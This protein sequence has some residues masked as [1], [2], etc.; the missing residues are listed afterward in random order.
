MNRT[1]MTKTLFAIL[2]LLS[3]CSETQT[4]T[5]SS[6][7]NVL[8]N[9]VSCQDSKDRFKISSKKWIRNSKNCEWAGERK[10][11]RCTLQE[12]KLNCPRTCD[13]CECVDSAERFTI[14][15][16]GKRKSCLWISRK[17]KLWRCEMFPILKSKCPLTCRVCGTATTVGLISNLEESTAPSYYGPSQLPSVSMTFKPSLIEEEPLEHHTSNP[18]SSPTSNPTSRP[19]SRP[20][21][22]PSRSPTTTPTTIPTSKSI[23]S[24][25]TNEPSVSPGSTPRSGGVSANPSQL[26]AL[27]SE[28]PTSVS[29]N[30]PSIEPSLNSS[31]LA[32]S[33]K[34]SGG[35]T[36]E[37]GSIPPT[38][39]TMPSDVPSNVLSSDQS[40]LHASWIAPSHTPS[41]K[42]TRNVPSSDPINESS[43]A[44]LFGPS[45]DISSTSMLP[46]VERM[47][48]P[49]STPTTKPSN[50]MSFSTSNNPSL[51]SSAVPT[52]SPSNQ[53]E[54][55]CSVAH[56]EGMEFFASH[57][58]NGKNACVKFQLFDGGIVSIDDTNENIDCA[59]LP[60]F[61]DR[62]IISRFD[63]ANIA[64]GLFKGINHNTQEEYD[65][66]IRIME[67]AQLP[68]MKG[69]KVHKMIVKRFSIKAKYFIVWL[70]VPRGFC[71]SNKR[72]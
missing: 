43:T 27:L 20:S 57:L 49:S 28:F 45:T 67:E 54:Q 10:W 64:F 66:R 39:V 18:T 60:F 26:A 35:N 29:T 62:I 47:D 9:S 2:L 6:I 25:T 4:V 61:Q 12:V 65:G 30:T 17:S 50:L 72:W 23:I 59:A 71:L 38:E 41:F 15:S 44:P 52:I 13:E 46:S 36:N 55:Y 14:P 53:K 40:L 69:K 21:N 22:S 1:T 7:E 58:Y 63:A 3:T 68:S 33:A 51:I 32:A 37:D 11:F 31:V 42:P 34:P 19:S 48:S 5:T 16:T 8:G 70:F 24:F 56:F